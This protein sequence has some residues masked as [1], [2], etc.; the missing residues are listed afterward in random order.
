MQVLDVTAKPRYPAAAPIRRGRRNEA[1]AA[2][3]TGE[4]LTRRVDRS[5][6]RRAWSRRV[7]RVGGMLQAAFAVFWLIRGAAA[8]GGPAATVLVALSVLLGIA[9][10]VYAAIA[11]AG[12]GQRPRGEQARQIERAVTVA[13]VLEFLAALV[14]PLLVISAGHPDWVLPSIAVTIGPLLLYLGQLVQIARY[15][16]IGWALTV[17]PL[18]LVAGLSGTALVATTGFASGLLLL[19]TS[20]AGFRELAASTSGE[21]R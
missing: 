8:I 14:L 12:K 3:G 4:E 1:L 11:T 18:V 15:R 21:E 20:V 19:V 9:V 5:G 7:L 13:T 16:L 2:G 6:A 10:F 17:G